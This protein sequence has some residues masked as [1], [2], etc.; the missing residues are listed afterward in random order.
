MSCNPRFHLHLF[1][2]RITAVRYHFD[3]KFLNVG[4]HKIAAGLWLLLFRFFGHLS[5]ATLLVRGMRAHGKVH[6][7]ATSLNCTNLRRCEL[8]FIKVRA[9]GRAKPADAV[10][11][12]ICSSN[13]QV[14]MAVAT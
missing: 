13:A 3:E 1:G 5:S 11:Q 12:A 14:L 2:R 4:A 9:E 7:S 6:L 8:P 10:V